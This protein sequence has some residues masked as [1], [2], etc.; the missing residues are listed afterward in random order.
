[1]AAPDAAASGFAWL[2]GPRPLD[3]AQYG[4]KAAWL[5]RA[6]RAGARVPDALAIDATCA[7]RLA[8]GDRQARQNL[9]RLLDSLCAAGGTP[10]FARTPE[11]VLRTSRADSS[12]GSVRLAVR[13]SGTRSLPGA[14]L[15][16]LDVACD[17]PS[18]LEALAEVVR[19]A[20]APAVQEQLG[21]RGELAPSEPWVGVLVQRYLPT[22]ADGDFG[23]VA[24]TRDPHSGRRELRGEYAAAG[25]PDVVSGRTRPEPLEAGGSPRALALRDA[26]AFAEIEALAQ[27]LEALFGE[28]LELEL[29]WLSGELWLLQARALTLSPR[30]LVRL[31]AEAIADD[32]PSYARWLEALA[33]RGLDA[34]LEQHFAVD[35]AKEPV[36]LRGLAASPGVASGVLVTDVARALARAAQEPVVLMRTD[37]APDDVRGFRAAQA[38]VTSSGGLTCHAAVIARGL[39]IPAVV[40]CADVR[41]DGVRG[42][43]LATR[44]GAA[45]PLLVEGDWISVDARAGL[46]YRGVLPREARIGDPELKRLF[47]QVR[48][49]RSAPVWA[50]GELAQAL[51]V[52][53]DAC[54]DGALCTLSAG[55]SLPPPRGREC[56]LELDAAELADVAT[57]PAG[58]GVVVRGDLSDVSI[59]ALRAA[60]PLRALGVRLDH[61]TAFL[62]QGRL[63]LVV[64]DA[65]IP[66]QDPDPEARAPAHDRD[67]PAAGPELHD[68]EQHLALLAKVDSARVLY[69]VNFSESASVAPT[70]AWSLAALARRDNVGWVYSA[71]Q[72]AQGALRDA[73]WRRA[74]R[75]T[76]GT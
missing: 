33:A 10:G 58:W 49:L 68:L 32:S 12:A 46:V 57:L 14:L 15:T 66:E 42:Q 6:Q 26:R 48:Q 8:G 41:V 43:V 17:P 44:G 1:M 69:A 23:A 18:V 54:L 45:G 34:L 55:G 47:T 76:L 4:L 70:S 30:A 51:R 38:V 61:P 31:A 36:L 11:A 56:W 21:A 71:S 37:A 74:V 9:E 20:Y 16:R 73:A 29:A 3:S 35:L 25:T 62:P 64:V 28:P 63:D 13:A 72:A 52:K 53:E 24:C 2:A 19:S 40:G 50:A 27:R 22:R 7:Q 67:R 59:A 60:A 39:G 65:R 75:G 5:D